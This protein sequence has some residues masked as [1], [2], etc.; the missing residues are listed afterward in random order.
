M[1]KY[2][3]KLFKP[4]NMLAIEI[5]PIEPNESYR[6]RH[7]VVFK[8]MDGNWESVTELTPSEQKAFSNYIEAVIDNEDIKKHPVATYNY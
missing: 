5:R 6:V 7:K 2:I 1:A 4:I 8:N 3:V